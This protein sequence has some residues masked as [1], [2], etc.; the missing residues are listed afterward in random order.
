M[1]KIIK[2]PI[3]E[4]RAGADWQVSPI[5]EGESDGR[6]G[7]GGGGE[8]I[9]AAIHLSQKAPLGGNNKILGYSHNFSH[10]CCVFCFSQ[11]FYARFV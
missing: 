10:H 4:G 7:G 9:T 8:H 1:L 2:N 5:N 3:K 11:C 6:N